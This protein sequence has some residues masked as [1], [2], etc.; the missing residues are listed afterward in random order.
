M[1]H[2][3][4]FS[5]IWAVHLSHFHSKKRSFRFFASGNSHVCVSCFLSLIRPVLINLF[6]TVDMYNVY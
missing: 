6:V 4:V 2:M 1:C 3:T 5:D